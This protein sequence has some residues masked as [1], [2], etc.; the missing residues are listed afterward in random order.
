[1]MASNSSEQCVGKRFLTGI[2]NCIE[3]FRQGNNTLQAFKPRLRLS[4][5]RVKF[6]DY[7][8]RMNLGS[9]GAA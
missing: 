6:V 9:I 4:S 7:V 2:K 8:G 1:M 5:I 3:S